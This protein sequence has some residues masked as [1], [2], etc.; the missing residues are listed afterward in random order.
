V[1][2]ENTKS[3][4]QTLSTAA[5]KPKAQYDAPVLISAKRSVAHAVQSVPIAE[6][7]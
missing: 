1:P 7:A 4:P 5:G 6:A 3:A 2:V